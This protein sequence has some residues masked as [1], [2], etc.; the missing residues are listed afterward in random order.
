MASDGFAQVII[1]EALAE[2]EQRLRDNM[3]LFRMEITTAMARLFEVGDDP[4]DIARAI[5]G[6]D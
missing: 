4:A 1:G 5:C 3:T 6:D 2:S